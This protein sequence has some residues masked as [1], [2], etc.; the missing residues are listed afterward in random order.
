M[1]WTLISSL[2]GV[3][4]VPV[5]VIVA[6]AM[7]RKIKAEAGKT[8]ADAVAILNRAALESATKSI[9]AVE[10][11][12]EKVSTEL[13]KAITQIQALSEHVEVLH[14]LLRNAG[15]QAPP[16]RFSPAL[17]VASDPGGK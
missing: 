11:R 12:A 2:A 13:D 9:E 15:I 17:R 10:R 16:F 3:C 7:R 6:L 4:S 14:G 5:S 1:N 8:E